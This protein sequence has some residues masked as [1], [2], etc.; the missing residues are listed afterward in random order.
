[1]TD[2]ASSSGDTP[3]APPP[4]PLWHLFGLQIGRKTEIIALVAFMLSV[5]GILW[6]VINYTRGA[7]VRLFP[8]EQMVITSANALGRNY[9]GQDNLLALI[10]TMSYVNDGETGQN[11]II[12]REYI[13]M[14]LGQREI[15]HRWYQFGSTDEVNGALKFERSSEARPFPAA[16]ASA[17]SHETL[18]TA[19]E[20]DC[21][22]AAQPC[23]PARNFVKWNDFISAIKVNPRITFTTRAEIY[24]SK[25]VSAS[26]VVQLRDYEVEILEGVQWLAATC[27]DSNATDEPQRKTKFTASPATKK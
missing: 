14:S 11:A 27:T 6:Q 19:W 18:F 12:R 1:M 21:T 22:Q 23:D 8:T 7:V 4:E 9:P 2:P 16:A 3:P 5:S 26:C 17:T 25:K 15:E 24:P 13:S 20:I 10:A